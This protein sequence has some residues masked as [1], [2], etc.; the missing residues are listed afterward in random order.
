MIDFA[1]DVRAPT[2]TAAAEMAVPVRA[3][4]LVRIASL[5]RRSLACWQRGQDARR[6]ELRA[7]ARA[8]P[9]ADGLLALPR[10]RLD[11]AGARFPRALPANAQIH[12][13]EFSRIAARLAP[14][15]LR[16]H[17]VRE[18]ERLAAT[19]RRSGQCLRVLVER[20]R[21]RFDTAPRLNPGLHANVHARRTD[22]AGSA[23]G[24]RH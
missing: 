23:S 13:R 8:L 6:T 22:R 11:Y 9:T 14:Q 4:L 24:F 18:R 21:E 19:A 15:M 20:R 10:Q 2:P 17:I 7:A 12:H 16:T 1:A 3:E 5:A